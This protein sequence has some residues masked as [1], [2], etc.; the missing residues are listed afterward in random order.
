MSNVEIKKTTLVDGGDVDNLKPETL[1]DLIR[2]EGE[3]LTALNDID[4]MIGNRSTYIEKQVDKHQKNIK[5]LV[6]LLDRK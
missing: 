1:I 6:K 2:R 4:W 5:Q 3:A